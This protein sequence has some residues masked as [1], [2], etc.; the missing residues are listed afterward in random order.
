MGKIENLGHIGLYVSDVER[1][2]AFYCGI[3]GFTCFYEYDSPSDDGAGARVCFVRSGNLV[4]ELVQFNNPAVS[5]GRGDG[6]IDHIAISVKDIESV[7]VELEAKGIVFEKK[8]IV[9]MPI[10]EH[11]SKWLLFRGP[12]GEHLEIAEVMEA[13]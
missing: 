6:L 13:E 9:F 3:L 1:S 4:L 11:G 5:A 8:D 10:F 7:Q 12:D 2:K